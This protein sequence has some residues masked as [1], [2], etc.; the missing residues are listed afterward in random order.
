MIADAVQKADG[1]RRREPPVEI[2]HQVERRTRRGSC[3][4]HQLDGSLGRGEFVEAAFEVRRRQLEPRESQPLGFQHLVDLR[5]R[6]V[7]PR[8]GA[9]PIAHLTA[10]HSVHRQPGCL[11]GDVP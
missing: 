2:H 6:Q 5:S 8:V 7:R 11:A 3:G 1:R 10:E 9:D 4:R